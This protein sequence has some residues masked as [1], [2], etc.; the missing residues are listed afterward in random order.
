MRA[1]AGIECPNSSFFAKTKIVEIRQDVVNQFYKDT[2][3]LRAAPSR[4][5]SQPGTQ[6]SGSPSHQ[7]RWM[8]PMMKSQSSRATHGT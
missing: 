8:K 7:S 4:C 6:Q 3:F 1:R 2:S 5:Y